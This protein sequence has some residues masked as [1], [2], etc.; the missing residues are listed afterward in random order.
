MTKIKAF[1]ILNKFIVENKLNINQEIRAAL[2]ILIGTSNIIQPCLYCG[3][4][5]FKICDMS[6]EQYAYVECL[7][8]HAKSPVACDVEE[9]IKRHNTR[10]KNC[11][12][13]IINKMREERFKNDM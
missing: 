12:N 9:A 2:R 6:E 1:I 4:S 7:N 5:M 11:F 8:C 3:K 10:Y 13:E